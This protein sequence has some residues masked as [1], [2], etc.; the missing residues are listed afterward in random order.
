MELY[1][2]IKRWSDNLD[3]R[4]SHREAL[5]KARQLYFAWI[6]ANY[7]ILSS[8]ASFFYSMES[9]IP[10]RTVGEFSGL[11]TIL[12]LLNFQNLNFLYS[13]FLVLILGVSLVGI[14]GRYQRI[15]SLLVYVLM[16]NLDNKAYVILDG[17]N[18]LVHLIGF[19]LIFI[20][21]KNKKN[22][23]SMVLTNLSSLMIKCQICFVYATAGLLKVMGPLWNKGIALYYTMGVPEFGNQEIFNFLSSYPAIVA[24]LTLGT[25][26]FQISFPYLIWNKKLKPLMV[27]IGSSL[28]LSIAIGM[29]L[30]M[31]GL[32]MCMSYSF[33]NTDELEGAKS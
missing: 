17:G 30:F 29:G 24:L 23:T 32:A 20:D 2:S 25:V 13:T 21:T 12:N 11:Q 16:L 3:Q 22:S 18:N 19:Y 7:L 10:K 1:Q 5:T 15:S 6:F 33:F 26:A 31:F 8:K 27:L 4:I 14:W 9:Y 28:H